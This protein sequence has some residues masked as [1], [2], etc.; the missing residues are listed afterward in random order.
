MEQKRLLPIYNA[1]I[2]KLYKAIIQQNYR[3]LKCFSKMHFILQILLSNIH[4]IYNQCSMHSYFNMS[5]LTRKPVCMKE[6]YYTGR[7][8]EIPCPTCSKRCLTAQDKCF[9]KIYSKMILL[10]AGQSAKTN[11]LCYNEL[12]FQSSLCFYSAILLYFPL[13]ALMSW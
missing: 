4:D 5:H 2:G 9:S 7:P 12:Y 11:E 1:L 3:P 8:V 6:L 13:L 10:A